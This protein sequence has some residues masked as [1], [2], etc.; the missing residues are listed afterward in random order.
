TNAE[1]Y[2][3][4]VTPGAGAGAGIVG[5]AGYGPR[6]SDPR[7]G[8]WTW[9]AGTYTGESGNNDTQR[10][11]LAPTSEGQYA[12]AWRFRLGTGAW[13]YCDTDG[14]DGSTG[15]FDPTKLGLL[16]VNTP[17]VDYATLEGAQQRTLA[18]GGAATVSLLVY[19][20][21][22]TDQAGQG[23][24]VTVE[25][26]YGNR[27]T[28]P[29]SDPSWRWSTA[30][31]K[32]DV[33]GL[34]PNDKAN[35]RYEGTFQPT[36]GLHDAAARVKL[37][38][39]NF[40]YVDLDGTVNGYAPA[41]AIKLAVNPPPAITW[42]QLRTTS[43]VENADAFLL[44]SAEVY[45]AGI[46][47]AQGQGAGITAQ[48]GIGPR[49]SDPRTASGWTWTNAAYRGDTNGGSPNANDL[50]GEWLKA[51]APGQY[52]VAA[53][54]VLNGNTTWVDVDGGTP[55][56]PAELGTLDTFAA[57]TDIGFCNVQFPRTHSAAA[58][59]DFQ[60]YSQVWVAGLTDASS[61][62]ASGISSQIAVV[63]AGTD[64]RT[65]SGVVYRASGPNPGY[66]FAQNNDEHVGVLTAPQAAGTYRFFSRFRRNAGWT[67]CDANDNN[68]GFQVQD[69]ATLTVP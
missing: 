61:T 45:A 37:W 27:G 4:T 18:S 57:G 22:L 49:G 47:D 26:G 52:S 40:T 17:W 19:A 67:Y 10:A 20:E 54:F 66:N 33:D 16:D 41:Q 36:D 29:S 44:I 5:E 24:N 58:G 62:A 11:K 15:G 68:G 12:F 30:G 48:V 63:P 31:Y 8:G 59:T 7:S 38:N 65:A 53:R 28:E 32:A 64:P 69:M 55:F 21:G 60:V 51:P 2:A 50:Y 42:A 56:A 43:A 46:T 34:T 23:A 6:N 14:N 35:D 1:V 13:M 25:V 9:L 3:A 39:G